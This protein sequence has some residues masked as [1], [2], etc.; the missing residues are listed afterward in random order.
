MPWQRIWRAAGAVDP[1]QRL[2]MV[3][4]GTKEPKTAD[5]LYV[6]RLPRRRP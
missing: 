1:A 2:L 5:L 4:T 6:K 3:S